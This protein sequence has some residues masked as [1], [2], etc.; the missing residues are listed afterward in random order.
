M[1]PYYLCYL[2]IDNKTKDK[3]PYAVDDSNLMY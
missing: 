2:L 1:K 3:Y